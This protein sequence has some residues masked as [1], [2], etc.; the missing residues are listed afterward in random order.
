MRALLDECAASI[1]TPEE[2]RERADRTRAF[3]ESEFGYRL[4]GDETGVLS[5]RMRE[6]QS[7]HHDA[8]RDARPS[9]TPDGH[10]GE[11]A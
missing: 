8:L 4:S 2:L 7:A 11:V 5:V 10:V 6:A 3:L 1:L 9:A